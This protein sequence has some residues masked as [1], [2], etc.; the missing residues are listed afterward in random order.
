MFDRSLS[1]CLH[2]M[3][4]PMDTKLRCSLFQPFEECVRSSLAVAHVPKCVSMESSGIDNLFDFP[5]LSWKERIE[6]IS[7]S[8][9]SFRRLT[10][11]LESKWFLTMS[12]D[13]WMRCC[14]C[15]QHEVGHFRHLLRVKSFENTSV[16]YSRHRLAIIF[17]F[18]T[19]NYTQTIRT[20]NKPET[21]RPIYY[22][23]PGK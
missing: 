12:M 10:T 13:G 23:P 7:C 17:A 5:I 18:Y 22:R 1:E 15:G 11:E 9:V 21:N 6:R 19:R 8:P 4:K 16:I 14:C 3:Y 2:C 20:E